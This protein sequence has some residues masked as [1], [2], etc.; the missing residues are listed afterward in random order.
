MTVELLNCVA[1]GCWNLRDSRQLH[2][3]F[4]EGHWEELGLPAQEHLADAWG[5]D[6][7]PAALVE[8]LDELEGL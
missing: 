7:W 5:E 3:V 6:W 1:P 2:A 4:C 8:V